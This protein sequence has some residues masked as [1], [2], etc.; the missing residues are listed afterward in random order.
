MHTTSTSRTTMG[1]AFAPIINDSRHNG[2][3]PSKYDIPTNDAEVRLELRKL[4]EPITFFGER[5]PERRERLVR[6]LT[7]QKHTDFGFADIEEDAEMEEAEESED[8]EFYTPGTEQLLEARKNILKHS[9]TKAYERNERQKKRATGH[10]FAKELKHR[11][12]I[13]KYLSGL[14]LNGT[15]TIRGNTRTLSCARLNKDDTRV[16]CG[17]WD[18]NFYVLDGKLGSDLSFTTRLTPGCHSEKVVLDW[19]PND[20]NMLVS[21]GAEGK[22][23]IWKMGEEGSSTKLEILKPSATISA[24]NAR[25]AN[26]EHDPSG[27]YIVTT[28]FDQTWK[29]WDLNRQTELLEQEGHSKEVYASRFHPDGG[30]LATGGLDAIGRIWDLRSGRSIGVL[31]SHVKGI[32]SMDWSPNGYHLATAS[33]DCSVKIWDMRKLDKQE[34]FSIPA[35]T[36]IVS[37]VKFLQS[38]SGPA[39]T[40]PVTDEN[41]EN[42]E[43]LEVSGAYLSTA[44]YDGT[45]KLWSADNWVHLKTLSGH[46]DK[47]MSCDVSKDGLVVVSCGWDRTMRTWGKV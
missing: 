34:L 39:I 15:Y 1:D 33:G 2:N 45:V 19:S 47:V 36:K 12:C 24:H 42:P 40:S 7:E 30:L 25:I 13:A 38:S 32:Y 27:E 16:A 26:I 21:G 9:V 20:G 43:L 4:G 46:T 28:S 6:L 23:N 14:E 5:E 10:D 11:R 8:E 31:E 35:H 18:G 44:S 3:G 37:E 17:S 22:I 29:L 41:D